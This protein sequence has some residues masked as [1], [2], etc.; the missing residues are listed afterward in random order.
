MLLNES[1]SGDSNRQKIEIGREKRKSRN[2][3]E[4]KGAMV[5]KRC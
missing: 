4:K 3:A 2:E 5:Q 1:V